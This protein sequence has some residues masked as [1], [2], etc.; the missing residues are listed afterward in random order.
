MKKLFALFVLCLFLLPTT[1]QALDYKAWLPILPDTVAGM[2]RSG[3]PQGMNMEMGGQG[4][5]SASQEYA[6][7]DHKK[8]L[9]FSVMAGMGS[10]QVQ[11]YQ[12]MA[13]MAMQM[14]TGDEIVKTVTVS[15]YKGMLTLDKKDN[16]GTLVIYLRNDMVAVLHV[17][18]ATQE[19]HLTELAQQLPLS[20]F[21]AAAK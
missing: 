6:S 7:K 11:G 4:W 9:T 13:T 2:A 3:E 5:S 18:P 17:E 15:G 21:A 8:T 16:S 12:A 1:A 20:K 14:E 19:S 10:P